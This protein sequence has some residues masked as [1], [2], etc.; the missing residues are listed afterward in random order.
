M[1]LVGFS[2]RSILP[3]SGPKYM[4]FYIKVKIV[5]LNLDLCP[6]AVA[7]DME[8]EGFLQVSG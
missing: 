5:S 1:M 8:S 7:S 3:Y 2:Y 4:L 6:H